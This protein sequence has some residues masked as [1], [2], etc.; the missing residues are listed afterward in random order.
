MPML[1]HK[2][3]NLTQWTGKIF[4]NETPM[5]E[6]VYSD[7]LELVVRQD[8]RP[9][10]PDDEDAPQLSDAAWALA[11]QCW[12]KD[13]KHRPIASA[14]CET[15][16]SLV[17][18]AAPHC[19]IPVTSP[20]H[21]TAQAT[22]NHMLTPSP[23]LTIRGHTDCV[24]CAAFSSDGNYIVSGS[25]DCTIRVWDA[26]TG[27]LALGPLKM[28]TGAIVCVAFS[29]D[30]RKIASG[31]HD[32][33]ILVWDAVVGTVVAG[34]FKGHTKSIWSVSF[35]P[36][37]SKIVSGSGDPIIRVWDVQTGNNSVGPLIEHTL[38]VTTAVFSGNGKT[39]ASG[40]VD[41][42]V[43]VWDVKSG[44]LV[45]G[46]LRGH[47]TSV[48]FVVFSPDDKRIVSVSYDGHVCMWDTDFGTLVSGPSQR[49]AEGILAVAFTPSSTLQAVSPNGKWIVARKDNAVYVWE[50]HTGLLSTIAEHTGYVS[51]VSFSPDSQKI[52][53]TSRD[54]TIQVR[55]VNW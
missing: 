48:Y 42:T 47:K 19:P 9:E 1:P 21:S 35:S 38:G 36:D 40:S 8:V 26:Q 54:T 32:N 5:G 17:D 10:R 6:L 3:L 45:R 52:L 27:N 23:W 41:C 7:F 20:S 12:A 30:G 18:T 13:P 46:P 53:S 14:V 22:T 2:I 31:S 16:S 24:Q 37:G 43:R 55:T 11:E 29:P 49:H 4:T 15:L 28:H 33:T 51:S 25:M 50:L 39:I 34:P 44:S